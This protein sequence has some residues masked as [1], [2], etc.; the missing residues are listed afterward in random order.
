MLGG[1]DRVVKNIKEKYQITYDP[2][3]FTF[4]MA[5]WDKLEKNGGKIVELVFTYDLTGE[6]L[7]IPYKKRLDFQKF[8][9]SGDL[10]E[11]PK[12]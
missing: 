4:C 9:S 3:K 7:R 6:V 12:G 11:I 2:N 8:L 10:Q 1:I 5:K